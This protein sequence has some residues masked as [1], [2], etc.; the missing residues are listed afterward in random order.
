VCPALLGDTRY[1]K[2]IDK[3]SNITVIE[4]K[5]HLFSNRQFLEILRCGLSV[6]TDWQTYQTALWGLPFT[7]WS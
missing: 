7:G 4:M 1:D 2:F 6:G 3:S 5:G